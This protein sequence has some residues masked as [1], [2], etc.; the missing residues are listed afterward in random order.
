MTYNPNQPRDKDGKWT[1][2]GITSEHIKTAVKVL[3]PIALQF[4][5]MYMAGRLMGQYKNAK[6][7]VGA[8]RNEFGS[9]EVVTS[10]AYKIAEGIETTWKTGKWSTAAKAS[11]KKAATTRPF[12]TSTPKGVLGKKSF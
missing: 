10:T 4:G 7:I 6:N 11:T 8:L 1:S 5:G 2:G 12:L 9:E 3:A